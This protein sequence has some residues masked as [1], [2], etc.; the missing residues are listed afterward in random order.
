MSVAILARIHRNLSLDVRACQ[1]MWSATSAK[2]VKAS[3]LHRSHSMSPKFRVCVLQSK[4]MLLPLCLPHFR[5]LSPI[6]CT[7]VPTKCVKIFHK[8]VYYPCS[9]PMFPKLWSLS[10]LST[11]DSRF[12]P[13]IVGSHLAKLAAPGLDIGRIRV[14]LRARIVP[15]SLPL[16]TFLLDLRVD[17]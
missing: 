13:G 15:M 17:F 16:P 9:H 6:A 5:F 12:G 10:R 3:N 8:R 2:G 1:V 14:G 7:V 11:L 4:S